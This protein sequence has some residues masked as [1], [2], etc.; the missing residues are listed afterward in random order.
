MTF[1]WRRLRRILLVIPAFVV[2]YI[3]LQRRKQKYA[4]RYAS[5]SRVKD[6]LGR[7]PGFR[8]HIPPILF[9][10]GLS[11]MIAAVARPAAVV[12]LPLQES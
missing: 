8:R 7:G 6:A 11:V 12:A 4:L 1:L 10:L 5:L 9:L 3:L 2:V